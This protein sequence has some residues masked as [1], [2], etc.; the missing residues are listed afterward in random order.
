ML[1]ETRDDNGYNGEQ[2]QVGNFGT[3]YQRFLQAY[4]NSYG[5]LVK[6]GGLVCNF[7]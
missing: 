6:E 3:L 4:K 5:Q 2:K 1:T 7:E